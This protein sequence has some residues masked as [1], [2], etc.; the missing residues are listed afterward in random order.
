MVDETRKLSTER[1]QL[2]LEAEESVSEPR[3]TGCLCGPKW[4]SCDDELPKSLK[5]KTLL[6]PPGITSV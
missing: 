6:F 3:R 2:M 4:K 5:R 1:Y